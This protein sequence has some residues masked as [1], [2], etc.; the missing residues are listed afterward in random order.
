GGPGAIASR[1]GSRLR[2]DG[3]GSGG[4]GGGARDRAVQAGTAAGRVAAGGA[5]A[6]ALG[7]ERDGRRQP[8]V[9]RARAVRGA[10]GGVSRRRGRGVRAEVGELCGAERAR[11]PAGARAACPWGGRRRAR[12]AVA[13]AFAGAGGRAAGGRQG[14]G[15]VC[16]AGR[17]RTARAPGVHAGG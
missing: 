8:E 17:E 11:E 16:A 5:L 3:A 6:G 13:A 15:S 14:G 4:G 12:G 10:G 2:D 7:L 1:R 9:L